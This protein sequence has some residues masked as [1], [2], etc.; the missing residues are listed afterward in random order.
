MALPPTTIIIGYGGKV[1]KNY[2]F[3]GNKLF[4]KA[5][6][7]LV[8]ILVIPYNTFITKTVKCI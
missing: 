8:W 2:I 5:I 4:V 6:S 3:E 1:K 7:T